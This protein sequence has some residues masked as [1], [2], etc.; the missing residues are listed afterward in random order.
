[1]VPA[2]EINSIAGKQSSHNRGN[3]IASGAQQQVKMIGDQR[4]GITPG[5]GLLQD[6]SQPLSKI[7][8]ILIIPEYFAALDTAHD[9]VVQCAWS[10]YAGLSWHGSNVSAAF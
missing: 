1:M 4:P 2:V 10:V 8:P 6:L 3:R 5:T 7:V 9:N